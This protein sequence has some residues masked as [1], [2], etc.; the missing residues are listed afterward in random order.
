MP[1][2]GHQPR[3]LSLAACISH[4]PS[5]TRWPWLSNSL[6][7]GVWLE[8][9]GLRLLRLQE[10]RVLVV[11]AGQQDDPGAGADAAD[12][13]RPCGRC[14]GSCSSRAAGGGRPSA[15]PRSARSRSRSIASTSILRRSSG[16][17]SSIGTIE[18]RP[19]DDP[20]LAVD[21]LG[22]PVQRPQAVLGAGLGGAL[23][24]SLGTAFCAGAAKL[25]ADRVLV[26]ARVPDLEVAQSRRS[27]A[28]PRG[29]C[30]AGATSTA[31]RCLRLKPFSR[32]AISKLAASR[33]TSHSQARAGVSSKS[34]R[35]KT[36]RRSGAAKT[37]KL[38][39][40]ASP[41]A[42]TRRPE[43]GRHGEVGGHHRRGAADRR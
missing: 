14:A 26:E 25:L 41:Q 15:S 4:W 39:R 40:W 13:R 17:S 30:A 11:A 2:A 12:A 7:A 24:G 8:H 23:L 22:E 33:L 20:Q 5:T 38:E 31:S 1:I 6:A 32:A 34:L 43:V 19:A 28:S 9:R 10:E 16:S 3:K 37:P 36:R 27:R 18:R 29:S 42:C 35:S 21:P